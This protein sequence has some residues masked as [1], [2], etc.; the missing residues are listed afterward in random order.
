MA[1]SDNLNTYSLHLMQF[2]RLTA[3][4]AMYTKPASVYEEMPLGNVT[5]AVRTE[6]G[7]SPTLAG[8]NEGGVQT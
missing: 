8:W 1:I 3:Q 6:F 7:V 2:L 4:E 5:G